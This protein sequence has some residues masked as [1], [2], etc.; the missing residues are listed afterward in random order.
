MNELIEM[1]RKLPPDVQKEVKDYV[2]FLMSKRLRKQRSKL[3]QEW[4]G[5]L[6]EFRSQY[7]ALTLED[8]SL[9]WRGD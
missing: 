5:A 2:E 6:R 8:K 1:I 9:D 4:A 7:T 3:S